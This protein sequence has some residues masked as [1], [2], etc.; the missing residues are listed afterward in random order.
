MNRC[1]STLTSSLFVGALLGL[2]LTS[3][4][5]SKIAFSPDRR[6]GKAELLEDYRIFRGTLEEYHPS[7][8]WFTP[9]D[10][11]D[12]FFAKGESLIRDSMTEVQFRN[13]IS[14]VISKV[15][16]G[17]TSVRNSK[18][19][20]RYLDTARLPVFPLSVKV[21]PD[22]LA[23]FANLNRTDSILTRGTVITAINNRKVRELVDTLNEHIVTDG[24]SM[25]GKY[26]SLSNRGGLGSQYRNLFGLTEKFIIEYRDAYGT[27]QTTTIPVFKPVPDSSSTRKT[28]TSASRRTEPRPRAL[29]PV[30]NL[31]IDTTLSSGYMTVNS[32]SQGNHL[33]RFINTSFRELKERKI[34]HLIIDVR[35]NGGGDAVLSTLLT[36]YLIRKSFTLADSL[37][38]I[39]RSGSYNR[40][41]R[42]HFFYRVGMFFVT[43]KRKDGLYHFGYFERHRYKPKKANHFDGSVYIITGGNSFSATTL[44]AKALKGQENVKL[45]GEETG[46]GSYGNSAWMI[47]DVKLPH[48]QLLFRLPLF[49]LVMDPAAVKEG[50]GVQPDLYVA[51][52]PESIRKGY[53]PKIELVRQMILKQRL[54]G[55]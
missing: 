51:S 49:R 41:I 36:R 52:T 39:R 29:N 40:Y 20:M 16:C 4:T 44:F 12:Y 24:W 21:W 1:W 54:Q 6:F 25:N 8:Y 22:S 35:S 38:A 3:C 33:R 43:R 31:Q 37:Y 17:H 32:F 5:S 15:R 34:N 30:R 42:K 50:R 7:L 11:I 53:D 10:S 26:Q 47:P 46:G 48:S 19:Y 27:T 13:I 45:V 18:K 9:K 28:D 55:K 23:V 14:Y 2:L